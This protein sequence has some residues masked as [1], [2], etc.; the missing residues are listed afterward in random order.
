VATSVAFQ[1]I[2][3]GGILA[4]VVTD[5]GKRRSQAVLRSM[6]SLLLG[7]LPLLRS[8]LPTIGELCAHRLP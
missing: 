1:H 2:A 6:V 8:Y 3:E 7:R 5:G 4:L